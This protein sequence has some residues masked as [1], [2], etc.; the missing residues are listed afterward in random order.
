LEVSQIKKFAW[1]A[2]SFWNELQIASTKINQSNTKKL[3]KGK[4]V[5][6]I[7]D[8]NLFPRKTSFQLAFP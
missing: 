8:T 4:N 2:Q 1:K 7:K 3:G 6:E 5:K